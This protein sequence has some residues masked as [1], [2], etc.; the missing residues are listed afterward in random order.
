MAGKNRFEILRDLFKPHIGRL[1][2]VDELRLLF[3]RSMGS[4]T[5]SLGS[6]MRFAQ[7]CKLIHEE[8][9][10]KFRILEVTDI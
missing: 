1:M 9:S 10:F 6:T 2:S 3:L 4:S 8:E 7:D 5:N